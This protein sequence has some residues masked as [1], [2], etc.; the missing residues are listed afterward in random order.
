[1]KRAILSLFFA[2][3]VAMAAMAQTTYS[4]ALEEKAIKGD[5]DAMLE[6]STCYR[7]AMGIKKDIDWANYWLEC[8]AK[9]G[10]TKALTVLTSLGDN[11]TGL[12]DAKRR[13]L[14]SIVQRERQKLQNDDDDIAIDYSTYN[15]ALYR[16]AQS[17]DTKAQTFLGNCYYGGKGVAKDYGQAVYWYRKAA[18]QGH[19]PAQYN[20]GT[21]YDDG[22]GV[23]QNYSQAVYWYRKAADQDHASA[24]NSLGYCYRHGNGVDKSDTQ[25]VYWYRKSAEQGNKYGQSNLGFC[26]EYGYGVTKDINQAIYWYRKAAD[27]GSDDAQDALKRLGADGGSSSNQTFT[28]GGV[29]FTMVYVEGGTF[30][31][32]ATSEQ[33]SDAYFDEKPAHVVTLSS[34]YIGET[35]V[36]QELWEA[37]MG[38]NPSYFRGAKRP[39]E[40]VSWNDCQEFIRKLSIRTGKNFRL[41]TEAEWEFAARG[42]NKSYGYKYSGGNYID[43][44]AWYK[45]NGSDETHYVGMKRANELGLYDMSGNVNEWCS[46]WYNEKY[47]S[48][49]PVLNPLGPSTGDERVRR[50]GSIGIGAKACRVPYRFKDKVDFSGKLIGL[51]IAM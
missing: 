26:Y 10:S 6:L 14:D 47:Y 20:L 45:E 21:C 18:D 44:V 15:D 37:V 16:K 7:F 39:V 50:G 22:K 29:S 35:E 38:N 33:G 1:M 12:K 23:S 8:A 19:A 32:G 9:A 36:T 43:Q 49:S 4:K 48:S 28:V 30:S 13:E 41:P 34:Y 17:G 25:A 27:Q 3:L 31:M 24:Q 5:A 40:N 46:D 51:R 2:L 11:G 42:G